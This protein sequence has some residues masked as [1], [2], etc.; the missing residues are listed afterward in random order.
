MQ[1]KMNR[2]HPGEI[3]NEEINVRGLSVK[4]LAQA[5][6]VPVCRVI[7]IVDGQESVTRETA[8]LLSQF[9]NTSPDFWLN[10]QDSYDYNMPRHRKD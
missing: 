6:L 3:L 8:H 2:V 4:S 7:S 10:L 5:L 9:F 1:N